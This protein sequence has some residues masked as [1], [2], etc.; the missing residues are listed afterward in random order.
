MKKRGL[1]ITGFTRFIIVLMIL[2]PGSFIASLLINGQEVNME[3]VLN[4]FNKSEDETKERDTE[5]VNLEDRVPVEKEVLR[6]AGL[7]KDIASLEKQVDKLIRELD[8]QG[9]TIQDLEKRIETLE[10][11]DSAPDPQE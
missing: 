3:N 2:I 8:K 9:E 5:T 1:R 4:I 6:D 10:T 7:E 11:A